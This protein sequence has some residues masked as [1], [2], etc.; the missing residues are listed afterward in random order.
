LRGEREA[1]DATSLMRSRFS[2]FALQNAPYLLRTV[3]PTHSDRKR[4]EAEV[5]RDLLRATRA[6]EY[7]SLAILDAVPPDESGRAQVEFRAELVDRGRVRSFIERSDFLHDGTG[8]RY[9]S[10]KLRN[11]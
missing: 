8:W 7:R 5:L 10:G 2:A 6:F 3:H 9:V 4:P 11:D 1:P